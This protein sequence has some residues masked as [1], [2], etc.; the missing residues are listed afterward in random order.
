M[1]TYRPGF[2]H[3]FPI[4]VLTVAHRPWFADDSQKKKTKTTHQR[5]RN[6]CYTR[7][8]LSMYY[9]SLSI[10]IIPMIRVLTFFLFLLYVFFL[11][12]HINEVLSNMKLSFAL[13]V[14][15]TTAASTAMAVEDLSP[16]WMATTIS[17]AAAI[18]A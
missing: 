4:I 16:P 17:G 13:F 7:L 10:F 15:T 18:P 11:Y 1:G 8:L 3:E 6:N 12:Q 9:M 14:S 2:S 5:T